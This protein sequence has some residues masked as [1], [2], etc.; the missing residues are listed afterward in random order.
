MKWTSPGEWS[1]YPLGNLHSASPARFCPGESSL[2]ASY[3]VLSLICKSLLI[4]SPAGSL[5]EM[6]GLLPSPGAVPVPKRS[7][8]V[9]HRGAEIAQMAE[10]LSQMLYQ[11]HGITLKHTDWNVA[12]WTGSFWV[13][14]WHSRNKLTGIHVSLCMKLVDPSRICYSPPSDTLGYTAYVEG[15]GSV[16]AL[17]QPR[18]ALF[19]VAGW[20]FWS[21]VQSSEGPLVWT[22]AEREEKPK[23]FVLS[24]VMNC[25]MLET[26]VWTGVWAKHNRSAAKDAGGPW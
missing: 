8:Q 13:N 18:C 7:S 3:C 14:F 12:R 5:W 23:Y 17:L 19:P 26:S 22:G 20:V 2:R 11:S 6:S 9:C 24:K 10:D 1:L 21:G 16:S 4:L 15:P 25:F